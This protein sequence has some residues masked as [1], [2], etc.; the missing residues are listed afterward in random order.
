MA[1]RKSRR[2]QPA[3]ENLEGRQ[4]LRASTTIRGKEVNNKDLQRTLTQIANSSP[5][6]D[7]RISY[8]TPQ[9]TQVQITLYGLGTL[10]GTTVEPDGTLDLVYNDTSTSSQIVGHTQGGTG[11]ANI[12]TLRDA[13]ININDFSGIGSNEVGA[14][15]LATFNLV[16]G[17]KINLA[18]GVGLLALNTI[19]LNTQLDLRAN[20]TPSG[21]TLPSDTVVPTL[22][23][24]TTPGGGQQ[25]AGIGG[26]TVPGA[27]VGTSTSNA[28]SQNAGING[29]T[30]GTNIAGAGGLAVPGATSTSTTTAQNQQPFGVRLVVNRINGSPRGGTVLGDA[31]MFGY[32]PTANV[33]LRIDAVNGNVLQTI[34]LAG[35]GSPVSGVGLGRDGNTLVVLVGIGS[36]V[37]AFNAITGSAVGSFSTTSLAPAINAIDG[38]AFV[39][40]KTVVTDSNSGPDGMVQI[41]DVTASLATGHAVA[42]GSAFAPQ[43][44]FFLLGGATGVAGLPSAFLIGGAHFDT[45][46]PAQNQTGILTTSTT[47]NVLK[48]TARTALTLPKSIVPAGP[49]RPAPTFAVGSIDQTVAIVTAVAN[50]T[51]TVSLYNPSNLT[52]TGSLTINYPNALTGL[53]ESFHPEFF[54]RAIVN[55]GGILQKIKAGSVNGLILDDTGFLNLIDI[56]TAQNSAFI[57]LPVAHVNIRRRSNVTILSSFRPAFGRGG[58][59]MIKNLQAMGP[60]QLP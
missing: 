40:N 25:L 41:I 4:L 59:T 38:M 51:N 56:G 46:T 43:R 27:G 60:F 44:S 47:G 35:L 58:V 23:F 52:E 54:E 22:T 36:T 16:D 42:V 5:L 50:G 29:A 32:D 11:Q 37:Q 6:S 33:L 13:D 31:Q 24:F 12:R 2:A 49:P 28:S 30:T 17:G 48:E 57:G 8:T 45:F 9:G 26:L 18:G 10:K 55:V 3:V 1:D 21:T 39:D 14:V 15:K 7:R 20:P 53:S 19:G 34:P